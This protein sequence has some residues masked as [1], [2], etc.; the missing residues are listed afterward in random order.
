MSMNKPL[1]HTLKYS[2]SFQCYRLFLGHDFKCN[3]ENN[4]M[5]RRRQPELMKTK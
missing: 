1:K 3:R 5:F 4:L 2:Y